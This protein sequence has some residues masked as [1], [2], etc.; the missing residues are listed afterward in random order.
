MVDPTGL[1]EWLAGKNQYGE[2]YIS[3]EPIK[4]ESE[5]K[6]MGGMDVHIT[7]RPNRNNV[8]S[9]DIGFVQ[10]VRNMDYDDTSKVFFASPAAERRHVTGG[11]YLDRYKAEASG[12]YG[13]KNDGSN[14]DWKFKPGRSPTNYQEADLRDKPAVEV[15]WR[16]MRKEFVTAVIAYEGKDKGKIYGVVN[17]AMWIDTDGE[18]HA[19][20]HELLDEVP[21]R[22]IDAVK[23][24]NK[25]AGSSDGSKNHK[26]QR[27]LG[28]FQGVDVQPRERMSPATWFSPY[29]P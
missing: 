1:E 7:F 2:F 16:K 14:Y 8:D 24:W 10:V 20:E 4:Y 23:A 27:Q 29:W 21:T 22:W 3:M 28:P 12:W 15:G 17:W 13:V 6:E 19:Y 5:G 26:D 25:Q 11:W 9:Q 18:A